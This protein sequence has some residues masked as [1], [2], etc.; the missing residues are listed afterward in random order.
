[1]RRKHLSDSICCGNHSFEIPKWIAFKS[2]LYHTFGWKNAVSHYGIPNYLVPTGH[3]LVTRDVTIGMTIR[4]DG[5]WELTTSSCRPLSTIQIDTVEY[6]TTPANANPHTIPANPVPS[7]PHIP[8]TRQ[9]HFYTIS[10]LDLLYR[11]CNF[12]TTQILSQYVYQ[13]STKAKNELSRY[14]T[15]PIFLVCRTG[16]SQVKQA[17]T[18]YSYKQ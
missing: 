16:K 17:E 18:V 14:M 5:S 8:R 15:S 12:I 13:K 10:F 2:T 11:K 1:M 7:L 9:Q 3:S 4:Q 6:Y